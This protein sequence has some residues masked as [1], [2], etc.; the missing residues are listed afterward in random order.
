MSIFD[1]D[2]WGEIWDTLGKNRWRTFLTGFGVAWGIALLIIMMASGKGLQN[3][4]TRDMGNFASNSMFLW[5]QRTSMP[6]K[7]FQR[8]RYFELRNSDVEVIKSKIPEVRLVCPRTQLGGYRGS[9]NVIHKDKTGA[10]T[11]YGDIPEYWE[12][13]PKDL[14]K[15]RW[16]NQN[17]LAEKRKVC[18]IG[19]RVEEMLFTPGEEVVGNSLQI[20]GVYFTVVGVYETLKRGGDSEEDRQSIFMPI[21][22]FQR[23]FNWGDVI[24]WFSILGNDDADMEIVQ[25]Q[26]KSVLAS[27]HTVHP[28]DGRAFGSWSMQT[29]FQEVQGLFSGIR[30]LSLF[31]SVFSLLA[32]AIGVSNIMLV[33][34]KERTR[35]LGVRRAIGATPRQII[36]QIM[37]E[38]LILTVIA[39]MIGI[40]FGA[41]LMTLLDKAIGESIDTFL[42]PTVAVNLVLAA[43]GILVFFGLLAGLLPSYRAV[44]VKPVEALRA[45]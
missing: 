38:A 42:H 32:G 20:N 5:T 40:I 31:V 45:E 12:I 41:G 14:L 26:V 21:S 34:V 6:Y 23:A 28:E 37:S 29:E 43:L 1:A 36:S 3:G 8:G 17:D 4:I 44:Q 10:F 35:E 15:G 25:Q 2:R 13:E 19:K 11:V 24:G 27:Q 39:G 30:I 33:V 7:G 18:V 16:L 9:N 22:T